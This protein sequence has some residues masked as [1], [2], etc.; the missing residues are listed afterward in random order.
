M[1]LI[2]IAS[3]VIDQTV[4]KGVRQ[5]ADDNKIFSLLLHCKSIIYESWAGNDS[6][7]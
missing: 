7:S 2:L 3:S 4:V 1:Y 5:E 6:S